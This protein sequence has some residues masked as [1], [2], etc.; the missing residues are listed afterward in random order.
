[1]VQQ[2]AL[3]A[4]KELVGAMLAMWAN[5][6]TYSASA[7]AVTPA[8]QVDPV[9]FAAAVAQAQQAGTIVDPVPTL[10]FEYNATA[11]TQKLTCQGVLTDAMRVQLGALTPSAVVAG[12]LLAVRN[13]AAQQ[14][15]AL[16]A[17]L[18]TIGAADLDNYSRPFLGVDAA[19]RQRLVKAELVKVFSPHLAR[20][21]SRQFVLQT[22]SATLA[23]DPSLTEALVTD[24]ALLSDPGH[25][26]QSL[27]SAFLAVGNAGVI[28]TYFGATD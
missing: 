24:A 7:A 2:Q 20:K 6:Q 1:N 10:V 23:S 21:L 14:F 16:A 25:P 9:A 8:N 5:A 11:Q 17:N 19:R 3:P 4:Y 28:A 15:Q 22:V 27:L 18:L 13:Q 12:L 26:G